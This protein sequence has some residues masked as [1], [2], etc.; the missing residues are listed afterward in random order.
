MMLQLNPQLV[1]VVKKKDS[2]KWIK[3][4]AFLVIDYSQDHDLLFA[5]SLNS[6]GEIWIVPND[7]VRFENN[8]SMKRR[9]GKKI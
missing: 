1:V 8:W 5:V 4:Y 9:V 6:T 2:N 7:E 3:G